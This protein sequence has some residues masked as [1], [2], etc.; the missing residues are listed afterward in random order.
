MIAGLHRQASWGGPTGR[1][2]ALERV[3]PGLR[4]AEGKIAWRTLVIGLGN[5][6]LRDDGV[7]LRMLE[8]LQRDESFGDC[9][10]VDGGTQ[11]IA[12]L[13]YFAE[14][15][16]AVILDAVALGAAPGTVHV[17]REPDFQ[18]VR[19]STAHEGGALE[20]LA[21]AKLLGQA[22]DEVVIVGIEPDEVRTGIG[23]SDRVEAA[24]P[25][26]V[27]KAREILEERYVP[28]GAGKNY[29]N[30]GH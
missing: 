15:A 19:G 5:R 14:R 21:L 4:L 8:E 10:C 24:L 28:G 17:I 30:E 13:G 16:S 20:V 2:P 26:A 1:G 23:L 11:G 7:G 25:E 18:R 29:R 9:E 6:L 12:L 22:P 3:Q 27:A